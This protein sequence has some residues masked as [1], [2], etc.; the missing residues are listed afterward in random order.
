MPV[1]RHKQE[2]SKRKFL[3]ASLVTLSSGE[4]KQTIEGLATDQ[5]SRL[6]IPLSGKST[7]NPSPSDLL[8]LQ[9]LVKVY[10]SPV[11]YSGESEQSLRWSTQDLLTE[12]RCDVQTGTWGNIQL[13]HK[14]N[15]LNQQSTMNNM[16]SNEPNKQREKISLDFLDSLWIPSTSVCNE[17]CVNVTIVTISALTTQLW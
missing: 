2:V 9:P 14:L 15:K 16:K 5:R 13:G 6:N 12:D 17:H 10:F 1:P 4:A 7:S 8:P 3:P 11:W